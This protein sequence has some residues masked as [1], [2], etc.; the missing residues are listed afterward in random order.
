MMQYQAGVRTVV[1]G[2]LPRTGPMQAAS[3]TRGAF[4]YTGDQLDKDFADA[5]AMSNGS[6]SEELPRIDATGVRDTG[7][8]ISS[9]SLNL[10]DQVRTADAEAQ[11]LQFKYIAADCRL[12]YT[13][14]NVLN[15]TQLWGDVARAAWTDSSL[16]V[17]NST[18]YSTTGNVNPEHSPPARDT[19][20]SI[21][22]DVEYTFA[23]DD[24]FIPFGDGRTLPPS[25]IRTCGPYFQCDYGSHCLYVSYTCPVPGVTRRDPVAASIC[26]PTCSTTTKVCKFEDTICDTSSRYSAEIKQRTKMG[27]STSKK[28]QPQKKTVASNSICVPMYGESF[29]GLC[30]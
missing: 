27:S 1:M 15:L 3:G 12:Y 28:T 24:T 30:S 10:R 2:G 20:I 8:Y 9:A 23:T 11:P 22:P 6:T 17:T 26:V 29:E 13:L 18:G 14:E 16:C 25:G 7:M 4:P 21:L 5:N 19:S